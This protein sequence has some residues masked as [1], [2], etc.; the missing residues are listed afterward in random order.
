MSVEPMRI[1]IIG[2]GYVGLV[3]GV[4]LAVV[5]HDVT[6]VDVHPGVVER[7]N[8]G[9][10]PFFEPGLAEHLSDVLASGRFRATLDLERAV[11]QAECI[12]IAVGTP[13]TS[14]GIDLTAVIGAAEQVGRA[15]AL[16]DRYRVVVVKST[17][18][19]GTTDSVVGPAIA[20]ASGRGDDTFGL[21]MNPEFLREGAAVADFLNPDRVVIGSRDDRGTAVLR[22]VYA[23]FSCPVLVTGLRDAELIKYTSNALLA[24]LISFSNE[25]AG[26]CERTPG[27]DIDAVMDGVHLD[28]R[29]AP[30]V[31][32]LRIR[33]DVVS[34]LR[35]GSGFGGSCFP[36]DVMALRE[37]GRAKGAPTP[38]LDAVLDVN[39]RRPGEVAALADSIAGGL[40][41]KVVAML[42]LTFKADTDDLRESPALAL[43]RALAERG[44]TLRAYD[45]LHTSVSELAGCPARLMPTM[46]SAVSGAD[47]TVVGTGWPEFRTAD[48]TTLAEAMRTRVVLDARNYLRGTALPATITYWPIGRART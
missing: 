34:Y 29:L 22:R 31:D 36:K 4:C 39:A 16:D 5:G 18:V 12:L 17:V 32:G 8:T 6:C 26:L 14:D 48:W 9:T 35:A 30:V 21:C 25:V 38:I 15:M 2:S 13:S 7:I 3:S 40:D 24:T 45:P 20:R 19:P 42:G 41:G 37:F 46:I 44:A 47:L 23:P 33:P 1:T 27:T 43:L 11:T 28:R 10:P